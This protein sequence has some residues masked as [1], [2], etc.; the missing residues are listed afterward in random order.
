MNTEQQKELD[1]EI[2]IHELS[3]AVQQL[4]VAKAP[5]IDGLPAEFYKHFWNV[6]KEDMLEV[7]KKILI[8][9]HPLQIKVIWKF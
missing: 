9:F 3:K 1:S 7:K 8:S 5:G 4:S 2:T 6:I